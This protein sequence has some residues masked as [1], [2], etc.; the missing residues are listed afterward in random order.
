MTTLELLESTW[1][2]EPSILVGCALLFVGH[3]VVA[4]GRPLRSVLLYGSGVLF[5]LLALVSPLD[6]LG[7]TY[8]FSAHMM[9][10]L[11]LVLLVPP[12][13][14]SG[15][16]KAELR[17]ALRH[18]WVSR[19]QAILSEP[20]LAWLLGIGTLWIWHLPFLYNATLVDERIHI[21]E[22]LTFLVTGAIF[23][24]PIFTP[25][26]EYRYQTATAVTYL[27]LGAL[28]NTL[29]GVLLTFAPAGF[30]PYYLNPEDPYHALNLIR[31]TWGLDAADDQQLGGVLMWVL[32][33]IFFL[34]ALMIVLGRWYGTPELQ[35]SGGGVPDGGRE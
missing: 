17:S 28:T 21:F 23:W 34:T 29:L 10:H 3:L 16:P 31:N 19:L 12:L 14:I 27:G 22:H 24:W 7:D 13:M 4:R 8:L 25:L 15:L 11:L 30:Y 26:D 5:L 33:G 9:Q 35:S 6:E 18:G 20:R 32:G 2:P 1:E